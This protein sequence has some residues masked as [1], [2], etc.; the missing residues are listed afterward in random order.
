MA[1]YETEKIYFVLEPGSDQERGPFSLEELNRAHQR[2]E[3][4]TGT[5]Y[6]VSG[7]TTWLP[8]SFLINRYMGYRQWSEGEDADLMDVYPAHELQK[9]TDE[10]N[11]P[12][13]GQ[14]WEAA[15]NAVR[16]DGALASLH[17]GRMVARK[18]SPIW[19]KLSDFDSPYPP[20]KVGSGMWIMDVDRE[21]AVELGVLKMNDRVKPQKISFKAF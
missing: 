19:K 4:R 11:E 14:L 6:A 7:M 1:R 20:F 2:R 12:S 18:D 9:M 3:F 15:A 13:W 5:L 17:K 8:L 10:E 16:D 21:D